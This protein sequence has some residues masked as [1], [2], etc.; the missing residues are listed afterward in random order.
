[1]RDVLRNEY[2]PLAQRTNGVWDHLLVAPPGPGT[3]EWR[4]PGPCR[5]PECTAILTPN[6]RRSRATSGPGGRNPC[7]HPDRRRPVHRG[8]VARSD[9][10]YRPICRR[11]AWCLGVGEP[12]DVPRPVQFGLAGP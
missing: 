7:A 11:V 8:H 9:P 5:G 1:M 6:P 4:T 12:I 2:A 10:G 3:G